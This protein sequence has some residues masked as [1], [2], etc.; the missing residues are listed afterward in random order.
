MSIIV[1]N[2]EQLTIIMMDRMT[3]DE[4][5]VPFKP[6]AGGNPDWPYSVEH[7]A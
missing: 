7:Q 5:R 2:N 3:L 4:V 6:M 1:I